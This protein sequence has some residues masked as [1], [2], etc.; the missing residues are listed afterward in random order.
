MAT[1]PALIVLVGQRDGVPVVEGPLSAA[2]RGQTRCSSGDVNGDG[3]TDL[4]VLGRSV[5]G[6]DGGAFVF[7]NKGRSSRYR[8]RG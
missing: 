4:V 1:D 8:Y 6:G 2:G 5:E 7:L 3:T